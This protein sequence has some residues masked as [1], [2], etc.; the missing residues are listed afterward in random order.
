MT[1]NSRGAWFQLGPNCRRFLTCN[2]IEFSW[3]STSYIL[4]GRL[5]STSFKSKVYVRN[6]HL[7][8]VKYL[9]CILMEIPYHFTSQIDSSLVQIHTK[10]HYYSMSFKQVLF[11]FH[12]KIWHGFCTS[13]T[14]GI[15]TAFAKKMMG[16]PSDLVSFSIKLPSK[17]HEIIHISFSTGTISP[18]SSIFSTFNSL[19]L[20]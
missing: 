17:R 3:E 4:Q 5:Q 18:F 7:S 15:S 12:A 13:S 9:T 1:W 8:P 10:F 2:D 19:M 14:H 6:V 11:V 16:F 20:V